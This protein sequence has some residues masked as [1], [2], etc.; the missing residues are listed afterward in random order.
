MRNAAAVLLLVLA[1]AALWLWHAREEAPAPPVAALPQLPAPGVP[2]GTLALLK[3]GVNISGWLQHGYEN[4][5]RVYAPDAADWAR[6]RELG[7][8]HARLPVDPGA[9][10]NDRGLPKADAL[11]KIR[12]AVDGAAKAGLL[13]VLALQLPEEM[14]ATLAGEPQRTAFGGTWRALAA[15][16][17]DIPP[18]QLALEPLNEPG[19]DDPAASR[20]LLQYL[21]GEIRAVAPRHT[22]IIG[23]HKYSGID[24]LAAMTPLADRNV[25]YTFHFYQPFDFTHQGANWGDPVWAS[26]RGIPYP[27]SPAIVAPLLGRQPQ[28]LRDRLHWYGEEG[29]DRRKVG[30]RL[31]LALAWGQR[32]GV[33]VQCG[34]FGVLRRRAAPADR[35]AWLRDVREALEAGGA[36]WTLWDWSGKFGLV[37]GAQGERD[38]DAGAARALGLNVP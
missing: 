5:P 22:L 18:A 6:M 38:L 36:G 8:T 30:E 10:L 21:A 1:A 12:G 37:S 33:P 11:S 19:F 14:K 17:R 31:G 4:D 16:L 34:E 20:S 27:G 26:L 2:A 32:N 35:A 7:L 13:V 28:N 25:V 3:R 29:W 24:E 15:A 9:L 23:G